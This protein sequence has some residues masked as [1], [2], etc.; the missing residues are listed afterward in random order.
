MCIIAAHVAIPLTML[1]PILQTVRGNF[2]IV[3]LTWEALIERVYV[4]LE[5]GAKLM[6]P[7]APGP[8][9]SDHDSPEEVKKVLLANIRAQSA[10][11]FGSKV[12]DLKVFLQYSG[13]RRSRHNPCQA[14][15]LS[16]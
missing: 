16:L 10:S 1:I 13:L 9:W 15:Q 3:R 4:A 5:R 8:C 6:N 14:F 12:N 2:F 7:N 11:V